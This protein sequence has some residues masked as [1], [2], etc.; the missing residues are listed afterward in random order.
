VKPHWIVQSIYKNK[1]AITRA[2]NPDPALFMSG[3]T[4]TCGADL[5]D[6]DKE[7]I[8]GLVIAVGGQEAPVLQKSVTHLIALTM[9]DARC[10]VARNKNLKCQIVLPHWYVYYL[11]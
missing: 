3:V 2:F 11:P 9:D 8:I 1:L 4:I 10:Q 5:P 7:N 6:G